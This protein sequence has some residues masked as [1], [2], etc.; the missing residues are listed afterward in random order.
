MESKFLIHQLGSDHVMTSQAAAVCFG[1]SSR[2]F[3]G[4]RCKTNLGYPLSSTLYALSDAMYSNKSLHLYLE[5]KGSILLRNIRIVPDHT[6]S[7]YNSQTSSQCQLG[8]K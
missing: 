3:H 1:L 8:L 2:R 6:A 4:N 5:D 7:Y